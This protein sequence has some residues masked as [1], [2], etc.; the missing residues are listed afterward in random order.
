[1]F[2]TGIVVKAQKAIDLFEQGVSNKRFVSVSADITGESGS[3]LDA[4]TWL[5]QCAP[6]YEIS[7]N[8][9]D[10]IVV[11]VVTVISDLPNTNGDCIEL[12]EMLAFNPEYGM[13][14][15]KTFKG[16]PVQLEHDNKVLNRARGVIL[17]AYISPLS[18]FGSVTR[19]KIVELLA[20]DK[21]K[22]R[23]YAR[24]VLSGEMNTYSIGARYTEYQCSISGRIYRPGTPAGAYTQPGVPTYM[25]DDG[26]LAYRKLKGL[27]G[28]ETS[29]VKTPAYV[30]AI[31]DD[32]IDMGGSLFNFG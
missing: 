29:G 2:E 13:P 12:A 6:I 14:F 11:P 24:K 27:V 1:M 8:L 10:Y 30:S 3:R 23:E 22:D 28:F 4:H 17:D 32:L 15:Y 25:R 26:Q 16:K 18:G 7:P 5:P 31:G 21:T 20:I 19:A 9:E